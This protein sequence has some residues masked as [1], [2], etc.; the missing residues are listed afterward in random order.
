MKQHFVVSTFLLATLSPSIHADS[1]GRVYELALENDYQF[2]RAIDTYKADQELPIIARAGLLP[3]IS[4]DYLLRS[5]SE[6]FT[7]KEL[8]ATEDGGLQEEDIDFDRDEDEHGWAVRL[9]QPLFD[10]PAWY[11]YQKGKSEALVAESVF[12]NAQQDLLLRSVRAYLDVLRAQDDLAAAR[13]QQR[14]FGQQLELSQERYKARLIPITD[15]ADSQSA[16]DLAA[17][18]S[19]EQT[20]KVET[21]L[22]ALSNLT[23]QTHSVIN[24]LRS[25]FIPTA[26]EPNDSKNW[27]EAASSDNLMLL[28]ARHTEAAAQENSKAAAWGHSP[29]LTFS[30]FAASIDASGSLDSDPDSPFAFDP[31][32]DSDITGLE[33]R[34]KIPLYEGGATSANRRRAAHQYQASRDLVNETQRKAMTKARQLFQQV[35][36]DLLRIEGLRQSILSAKARF[37]AAEAGYAVGTRTIIDVLNAQNIL[38]SAER[39]YANSRYDYIEHSFRLRATGA[40]LRPGDLY[41]LD[42]FLLPPSGQQAKQ[43]AVPQL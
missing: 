1:L 28:A 36:S 24:I 33:L 37:D 41:R 27:E 16:Y 23:G 31:D 14:A 35:N 20:S 9:D 42:A 43:R 21:A 18:L 29:T 30:A 5:V 22:E 8:I 39:D 2:Q 10:A 26:P 13:A 17:V 40:R 15:V 32:R 6:D 34:L 19:I 4:A 25:D 7:A 3:E 11:G 38:F 12:A